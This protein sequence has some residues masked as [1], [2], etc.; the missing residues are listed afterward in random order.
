M[1]PCW[2]LR[3]GNCK[4]PKSNSDMKPQLNEHNHNHDV[5]HHLNG[6]RT[7]NQTMM[8]KT[9]RSTS[10]LIMPP[11]LGVTFLSK[12]HS[13]TQAHSILLA[14]FESSITSS[15]RWTPHTATPTHFNSSRDRAAHHSSEQ[16]TRTD[17]RLEGRTD[18]DN[19]AIPTSHR[20][21]EIPSPHPESLQILFVPRRHL[22]FSKG[23]TPAGTRSRLPSQRY[24]TQRALSLLQ[25][26]PIHQRFR[27]HFP[28]IGLPSR[29][30]K[31]TPHSSCSSLW[32]SCLSYLTSASLPLTTFQ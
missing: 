2:P 29:S 17:V 3:N 10:G 8:T 16:V 12:T 28:V 27:M 20:A 19:L 23:T 11:H 31:P 5:S 15:P 25:L 1:E 7:T 22:D 26:W 13:G 14:D 30:C 18:R 4:W 24:P 9:K 32:A 21:D 6:S